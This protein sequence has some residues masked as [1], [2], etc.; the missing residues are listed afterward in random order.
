MAY[1]PDIAKAIDKSTRAVNDLLGALEMGTEEGLEQFGADFIDEMY[2]MLN[3][4]GSG[5][6]YA[7]QPN[8]SSAPGEPPA[9]QSETYRDSW[10]YRMGEDGKGHYVDVG[11]PEEIGPYLEMGTKYMDPRPHLRPLVDEKKYTLGD[12]LRMHVADRQDRVMSRYRQAITVV[13]GGKR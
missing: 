3:H 13:L 9:P 6:H 4:P 11:S 12:T 5:R 10:D 2:D 8:P 7:G 1:D